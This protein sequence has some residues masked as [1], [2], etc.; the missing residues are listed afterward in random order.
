MYC[1][2]SE[3]LD[4]IYN[5]KLSYLLKLPRFYPG[6]KKKEEVLCNFVKVISGFDA[7]LIKRKKS[8]EKGDTLK[9]ALYFL[10]S[11]NLKI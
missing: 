4:L 3:I 1:D 8:E 2:L 10:S 9:F 5:Y 6:S 7:I 11:F